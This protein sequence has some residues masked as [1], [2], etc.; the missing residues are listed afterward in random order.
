MIFAHPASSG[1]YA[2]AGDTAEASTPAGDVKLA[3]KLYDA[4]P[5]S[6]AL[7]DH[8]AGDSSIMIQQLVLNHEAF[9]IAFADGPEGVVPASA[10]SIG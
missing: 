2:P 5:G 4:W 6:F 1:S 8:H 3:F 7:T 10:L 9:D